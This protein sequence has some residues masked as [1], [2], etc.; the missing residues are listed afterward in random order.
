MDFGAGNIVNTLIR[1]EIR[2]KEVLPK[3][4]S[5]MKW[6]AKRYLGQKFKKKQLDFVKTP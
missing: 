4:K 3:L 5:R 1:I 2:G 6:R